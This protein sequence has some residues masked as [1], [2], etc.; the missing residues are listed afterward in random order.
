MARR[1][2]NPEETRL[3]LIEA[4]VRLML[5]QGF[6]ATT[7]DQICEESGLSK[8]AFFH[9]FES[10]EE[11]TRAAVAWWGDMG[12]GLYSAAWSGAESDPLAQLHRMLDIMISFTERPGETCTCMVGMMSQELGQTHPEIRNAC[13]QELARWTENVARLLAAAKQL[14]PVSRNFD[15]DEIAWFLNSLWQ[16]S[17][18]VAKVRG[19]P[20]M[21]R[22]NLRIARDCI[23]SLFTPPNN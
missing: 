20:E 11:L 14:H 15:P 18:L 13:D 22:R 19:N 23:D 10:K 2:R 16:G 6:A 12:T 8:G 1:V 4:A 7:A 17:M 21:I 5:R 9:H 3:R